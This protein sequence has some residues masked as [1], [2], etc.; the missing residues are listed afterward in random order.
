MDCALHF[1][2]VG[3]PNC[4]KTTLFN[5][6]TGSSLQVG[7]WPGVTVEKRS[8]E[9]SLE[10]LSIQFTDLP[11][12]CA[13][14]PWSP[15]ERVASEF[16]RSGTVSGILAVVDALAPQRGL[17]LLSQLM[18]IP[19]PI[20]V[21]LNRI[22]AAEKEGFRYSLPRLSRKLGL[23]VLAVSASKGLGIHQVLSA[24]TA[25]KPGAAAGNTP[26]IPKGDYATEASARYDWA[27][28][29][30]ERTL[31]VSH[32]QKKSPLILTDTLDTILLSKFLGYPLLFLLL[33][34]LFFLSFGPLANCLETSG[35][36]DRIFSVF[37]QW[38]SALRVDPWLRGLLVDGMLSGV[39]AALSFLPGILLLFFSLSILEDTG[40]M[41]R[42]AF[43]LDSPLSRIG[44]SGKSIVAMLSGFG[45]TVS[46]VLSTRILENKEERRRT[47]RLLPFFSCS[48][49]TPVYLLIAS[50]LF[51]G[52][53]WIVVS[54]ICVFGVI[55]ALGTAAI[56]KKFQ[57]GHTDFSP[58][59]MEL[60]PYTRPTFHAVW[61]R[62]KERA[63][64]FFARAVSVLIWACA[65][66][67]LLESVSTKLEP[68]SD[69]AYSLLA[70]LGKWIAPIFAPCGFPFWQAGVAL[71]A[72]LTAKEN[73]AGTLAVLL[74]GTAAASVFT[75]LSAMSFLIFVLLYSPC[76]AALAAY[77]KERGSF[78]SAAILALSQCAIAWIVS[79]AFFQ[80]SSLLLS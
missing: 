1:A 65:V 55:C 27:E 23:P 74:P 45:C 3:P 79:T 71:L 43:L 12:I 21:I 18:E 51:P 29:I 9:A 50:L 8:G 40:Y 54:G 67:W 11:G 70:F 26:Y 77:R 36:L 34:M 44:L 48:A 56:M 35:I 68:V 41:A 20:L 38:L 15:E 76:A 39:G 22:D 7:N 75:P 46:A 16:L 47:L 66:I 37:R 42:A 49:K 53:E 24:C 72:G 10:G 28:N 13:L 58:F 59:V 61:N 31:T 30:L 5:R 62:V 19:L 60:P 33:T 25:L 6:L 14:S 52:K 57:Y 69:P 63:K 2:L 73:I 80:I 4:G 64:D 32:P 78:C 17:Y